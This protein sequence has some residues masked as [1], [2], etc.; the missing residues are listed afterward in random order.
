MR[1]EDEVCLCFHVSKRKV[2]NY[3]RKHRPQ[4]ASQLADCYGAGT[5]CGWCRV[6][7]TKMLQ[8]FQAAEQSETAVPRASEDAAVEIDYAEHAKGR[9]QHIA[10]G[11]GKPPGS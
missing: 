4:R 1:D 3:L 2:Q 7:L 9:A 5:G 10:E 8:Q 11:K 6:L